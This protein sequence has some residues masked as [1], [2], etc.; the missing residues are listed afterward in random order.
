MGLGGQPSVEDLDERWGSRWRHGAE[1]QFYSR[2]KVVTTE[3]KRLVAGGREA[4]EVVDSLEAERA[5]RPAP[6]NGPNNAANHRSEGNPGRT[7]VTIS[8]T[9]GSAPRPRWTSSP[10]YHPPVFEII[11]PYLKET[12]RHPQPGSG[13]A[14]LGAAADGC[15]EAVTPHLPK[16]IPYLISRLDDPGSSGDRLP[17]GG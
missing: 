17:H 2:R 11:L 12:L 5:C 8:R 7:W 13:R 14:D 1:F 10:T 16:F 9:N 3:I 4:R 6:T 15:I